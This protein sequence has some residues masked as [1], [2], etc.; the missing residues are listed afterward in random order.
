ME[1]WLSLAG[2]KFLIGHE[3][4]IHQEVFA[5]SVLKLSMWSHHI[6]SSE[7]SCEGVIISDRESY[8]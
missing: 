3:R 8:M 5:L 4:R 6:C 7:H 1:T 2:I